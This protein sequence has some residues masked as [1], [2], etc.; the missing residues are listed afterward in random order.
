[1]TLL[2]RVLLAAALSWSYSATLGLL[3][4]CCVSGSFS[5]SALRLPG[6]VPIALIIS[7]VASVFITPV[8]VW[9]LRTGLRNLQIYGPILWVV[10]AA[11][12]VWA[13]P[14]TGGRGLYG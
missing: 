3:F 10:L 13:I 8:A 1:M 14:K 6:V 11:Y 5:F 12:I 9:S 7:T 2:N 4:A